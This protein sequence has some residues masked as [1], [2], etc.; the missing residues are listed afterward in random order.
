[1]TVVEDKKGSFYV[2]R[3]SLPGAATLDVLAEILPAIVKSFPWPKSMRWGA[4][5][6]RSDAL[7]WVR[8]LHGIVATFGPENEEPDVV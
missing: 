8:P 4:A 1:A 3:I 5:S 6:S 2:A 7:R